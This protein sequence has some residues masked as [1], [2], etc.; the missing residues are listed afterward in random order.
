MRLP[1]GTVASR[2]ARA[3]TLLAKRLNRHHLMISPGAL[4]VLLAERAMAAELP[5]DLI[6]STTEAA[7]HFAAGKPAAGLVSSNVAALVNA[8]VKSM[9]V[10]KL[11]IAAAAVLALFLLAIGIGALIPNV[12]A[13]RQPDAQKSVL[14]PKKTKPIVIH[15]CVVEKVD[16]DKMT[17]YATRLDLESS[18]NGLYEFDIKSDTKVIVDGKDVRPADLKVGAFVNI[19]F[20]AAADGSNHAV[21]VESLGD[22]FVGVVEA[23]NEEQVTIQSENEPKKSFDVDRNSRVTVNGKKAKVGDLKTKMR[24]AVSMSAGKPVVVHAAGA[25][26]AGIVRRFDGKELTL[27]A[28][29]IPVK[30][31]AV[32]TVNGKRGAAADIRPGM[33]V[34]LL[35][36]AETERR[37]VVAILTAK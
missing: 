2:L 33:A 21:R 36:C 37:E 24:V 12:L 15:D 31:D 29:S 8:V 3:R 6:A 19:E 32:V 30:A 28:E 16:S 25:K 4:A 35:M 26:V 23:V 7:A 20:H 27:D 18:A 10:A 9:L 5:P 34:T 17:V 13:Q 1:E 11:K 14:E 22:T